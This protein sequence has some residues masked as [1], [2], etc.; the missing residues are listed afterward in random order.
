MTVTKAP[1]WKGRLTASR[2]RT[3]GKMIPMPIV[4]PAEPHDM[5]R[6]MHFD[7]FP[8]DR[9]IEIIDRRM[10]VIE[11]EGS[12]EGYVSW[13]ASGC[14]GK[15]YINKLVVEDG[16]R[17]RGFAKTLLDQIRTVL[18][19]R[20]FISTPIGNQAALRLLETSQWIK[21]G[22]IIG[23]LPGNE[24]EVFFFQDM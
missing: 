21:A 10:L 9:I 14:I 8:G 6:I 17:R 19:G 3:E 18:S 13:Q 5:P 15:D 20:V 23:L 7:S 11:A 12:V 2:K 22:E 1:P 4:R 16:S 24:A